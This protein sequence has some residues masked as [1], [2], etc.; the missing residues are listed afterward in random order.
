[1]ALE[2]L[3]RLGQDEGRS[4]SPPRAGARQRST[5]G[6]QQDRMEPDTGASE[7]RQED[8]TEEQRQAV[9]KYVLYIAVC[10]GSPLIQHCVLGIGQCLVM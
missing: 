6:S 8:Y 9:L 5:G 4:S 2:L 10:M 1:M 3:E 7:A